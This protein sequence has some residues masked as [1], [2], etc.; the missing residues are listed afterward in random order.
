MRKYNVKEIWLLF[1]IYMYLNNG[2][3]KNL[4]EE[5]VQTSFCFL[6]QALYD[7][8]VPEKKGKR[9]F[10]NIMLTRLQVH[11]LVLIS[12]LKKISLTHQDSQ[13]PK[14]LQH[15]V[16]DSSCLHSPFELWEEVHVPLVW[17]SR[18]L[19]RRLKCECCLCPS[20]PLLC[21]I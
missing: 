11:H 1:F 19:V 14:I 3:K 13:E 4:L 9:E 2:G 17:F 20:L 6:V 5:I 21:F 7:R 15:V 18:L 12:A 10:S 16:P 8:L